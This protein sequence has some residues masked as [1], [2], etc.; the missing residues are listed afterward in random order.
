MEVGFGALHRRVFPSQSS[1]AGNS[2]EYL[3]PTIDPLKRAVDTVTSDIAV[4][5]KGGVAHIVEVSKEKR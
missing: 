3:H 5:M 4:A 1:L 2:S